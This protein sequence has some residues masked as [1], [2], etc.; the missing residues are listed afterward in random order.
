MVNMGDNAKIANVFHLQ[1][2][3]FLLVY[4]KL[5]KKENTMKTKIEIEHELGI[6]RY[7]CGKCGKNLDKIIK[8]NLVKIAI[9]ALTSKEYPKIICSKCKEIFDLNRQRVL[10]FK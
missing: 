8:K 10:F 1:I 4:N 9:A 6:T 3:I 5:F 7:Y 2:L